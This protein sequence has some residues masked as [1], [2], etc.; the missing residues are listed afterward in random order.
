[1]VVELLLILVLILANGVFAGTELAILSVKRGRLEQRAAAGN[2]GAAT[3][4][5]LRSDPNRFLSSVQVGITLIGTL[6]G[7]VGGASLAGRL[8]PALAPLPLVGAYAESVALVLVVLALTYLTLVFGELVPKRIALLRAETYAVLVAAPIALLSRLTSPLVALLAWSTQQVLRLIGLG[9]VSQERVTEEDIRHLVREGAQGGAVEPH[10]EQI[11]DRVFRFGDRMVRQIMTPRIDMFAVDVD[12]PL[13]EVLDE[14][15]ASGYS[16]F[17]VY[18]EQPDRIVGVAHV[19]DVLQLYRSVEATAGLRTILRE[20]LYVPENSRASGLLALFRKHQRHMAIVI[21]ETGSVEGIVT[22]EDV[23]DE[24]VGEISEE[25]ETPEAPAVVRREDGSLLIDAMLPVDELKQ[26][27]TIAELPEEDEY[28]YD[29]L[30]GF[31]LSRFG[32]IPQP[33]DYIEGAGWYFEVVD[34]DGLRIDKALVRRV[35]TPDEA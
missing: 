10:E 18:E 29:T 34:M 4:L 23:L 17:P 30:A 13:S 3:A 28:R 22:L 15:I 24:I 16:R 9:G 26:Y 2:K 6:T 33:G 31:M 11:I 25:H 14:M 19:R 27:L 21:N 20:P 8:A 35:V 12:T 5:Q 1:M 32:R 7:A